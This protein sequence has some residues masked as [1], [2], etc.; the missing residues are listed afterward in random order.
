MK[1]SFENF[2]RR[3]LA[4]FRLAI[5]SNLEYRVNYFTDAVLQ[6]ALTVLIEVT[7]WL[8]VFRSI[9]ADTI[10]GFTQNDYLAYVLW[11]SFIARITSTW[12]YEFRMIEEVEMGSING[13]LV[14]PMS[15]FE[16]YLSQFLG[17]KL[18]TTV[19][20]LLFPVAAVFFFKLP[21]DFSRALPAFGL[22]IYYLL[23]VHTMSFCIAT[24]AF[25][26]NK[27]ASLTVAKNLSLWLFSGELF[28]LDLLPE[29]W[30]G[31]FV[32]CPF[33]NAV[34]VPVGYLTGRVGADT[35]LTGYASTTVGL[36]F[37]GGLGWWL[38]RSGLRQYSGTGA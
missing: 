7:L 17:Y 8:A 5:V 19:V 3:N 18:I 29:P 23:L 33:A 31:W 13:L 11:A 24:L 20:S 21:T 22:V 6:P 10:G 2:Y 4:F 34:Y 26:F 35:L 25:R 15:F 36:V 28:P 1:K 16:Y 14:R 32:A 12:M 37:F 38:W 30:R 9:G 27:V